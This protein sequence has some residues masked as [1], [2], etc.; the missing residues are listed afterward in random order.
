MIKKIFTPFIVKLL[1]PF[2]QLFFAILIFLN[3]IPLYRLINSS[4]SPVPFNGFSHDIA[5]GASL[6]FFGGVSFMI[7]NLI[8]IIFERSKNVN[9]VD[10]IRQSSLLYVPIFFFAYPLLED[11]FKN[12]YTQVISDT[13]FTFYVGYIFLYGTLLNAFFLY[14]YQKCP[15]ARENLFSLKTLAV[16]F[17]VLV[18]LVSAISSSF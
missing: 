8:A 9:V 5:Y 6:L 3:V 2:L 11:Y 10:H 16:F 4:L 17:V 14:I 1:T 7:A 15:N 18:L 13:G 12:G